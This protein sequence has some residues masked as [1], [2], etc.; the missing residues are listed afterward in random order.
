MRHVV[1]GLFLLLFFALH[2]CVTTHLAARYSSDGDYSRNMLEEPYGEPWSL[3]P[4][5]R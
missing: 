1:V 3:P 2:G 4:L 5:E